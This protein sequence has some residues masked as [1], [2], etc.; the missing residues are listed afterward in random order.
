MS[1]KLVHPSL[2]LLK[3]LVP[4]H[5]SKISDKHKFLSAAGA[6]GNIPLDQRMYIITIATI[7]ATT[8][9]M[10]VGASKPF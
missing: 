1:E 6:N 8:I 7:M 10:I 3:Y 4:A 5:A 2:T 9:P